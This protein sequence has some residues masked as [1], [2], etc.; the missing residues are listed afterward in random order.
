MADSIKK[1]SVPDVYRNEIDRGNFISPSGTSVGATVIRSKKGRIAYPYLMTNAQDLI[2]EFGAP[3]FTSG[4]SNSDTETPEMGYG[5]YA[6]L[7]FLEESD[8]CYVIR[9]YGDGDKFASLVF[10]SEGSTSGTSADGIDAVADENVPDRIDS[11]Y[12]LNQ[13]PMTDQTLLIGAIGPGED[14]NNLAVTIQTFSSACDWFNSYDNYSSAVDGPT[15][16]EN[17]PIAREVFKIN[18]YKKSDNED[19]STL[20]FSDFSASPIE[21]FYG[22]R[23]AMQDSNNKQLLI[24]EVVNGISKYIYVKPG[25]VNFT[26]GCDLSAI[27]TDIEPLSGGAFVYGDNIGSTDGWNYYLD[28]ETTSPS[29][30]ICPDY[31][32]DVKQYVGNIAASRMDCIAVVQ[33]GKRSLNTFAQISSSESYGYKNPSYIATYAGWNYITDPYNNK[34]L[35]IPNAINGAKLMARVDRIANTWDAPAGTQYGLL[36]GDQ[37]VVFNK[38]QIGQ[39]YNMNINCVRRFKTRG[40]VMWGQKTAQ[41]KKSPLDRINVR[42]LLLFIENS[43]EPT[44]LDFL[45]QPNNEST[46]LRISNIIDSF[47]STVQAGGGVEEYNVICDESNNTP[48][49]IDNNQLKVHIALIPTKTVEFIEMNIIIDKTGGNL[50]IQTN[51]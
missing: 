49:V 20:S 35:Y 44:L 28:R 38:T 45:F 10:D 37:N 36:G 19:W 16:W 41:Q 50:S 5:M 15:D 51:A 8:Q 4:T 12:A 2:D 29:I 33:T 13:Y 27:P 40:D 48:L 39:L 34:K 47:M 17:H 31:S 24:S 22:S 42:R 32:T 46:R 30:L 6:A 21:T 43:I 26:S 3:V 14:G 11:I 1:Y 25:T 7:S 23:T 18:V 9:D